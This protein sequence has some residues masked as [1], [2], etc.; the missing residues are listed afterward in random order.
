[1]PDRHRTKPGCSPDAACFAAVC[2]SLRRRRKGWCLSSFSHF[3]D[4]W[5]QTERRGSRVKAARFLR[6]HRS[7][8]QTLDAAPALRTLSSEKG[9]S[10][11]PVA[12]GFF[13]LRFLPGRLLQLGGEFVLHFA[14]LV[15]H[16]VE[17]FRGQF[18]AC[19]QG[20]QHVD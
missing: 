17:R 8:A 9:R 15:Q 10:P 13:W 11:L 14:D 6:V 1:M 12:A 20:P 16:F 5:K 18:L 19:R 7:V 4:S 2:L 3:F